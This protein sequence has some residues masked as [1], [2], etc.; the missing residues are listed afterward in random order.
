MSDYRHELV[1]GPSLDIISIADAERTRRRLY[2]FSKRCL[3]IAATVLAA[4]VVVPVIGVAALLVRLEGGKAFYSQMRVGKDGQVFRMW[5]LRTMRPNAAE[6][7]E[8]YLQE[9]PEARPEWELHQKLRHDPRVTR[10]GRFLRKYS[11]DEL[12]QLWNVFVGQM[13]LVGPRPFMPEQR[14]QYPGSAYYEMKPGLTGL[15][16]I[17]ERNN[18]TFAERAMHDTRYAK[19]MSFGT[20]LKILFKTVSVVVNG[21]GH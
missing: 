6:M 19:V 10:V 15:W 18:C 3:D 4:P 14:N 8:A 21:T 20:D 1:P 2:F 9:C 13:T 7:L 16:Q 12:P 11:L 5:K 17:S